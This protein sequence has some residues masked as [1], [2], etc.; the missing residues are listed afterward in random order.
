LPDLQ[1]ARQFVAAGH[2]WALL[3]EGETETDAAEQ[4]PASD[5]KNYAPHSASRCI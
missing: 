4:T 5:V 1:F 2:G 3:P